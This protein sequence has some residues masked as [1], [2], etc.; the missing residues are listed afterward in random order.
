MF[1]QNEIANL[2]LDYPIGTNDFGTLF[3]QTFE[4]ETYRSIAQFIYMGELDDND[5]VQYDD[6]YNKKERR[7]I[8]DNI[9]ATVQQRFLACQNVYLKAN[10]NATFKTYENVGHWT[11][12]NINLDVI[13]FFLAQMKQ[14][15]K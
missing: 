9:G 10:I 2:K 11:T 15:E 4:F 7:I 6:A 14:H 5:A 8:N 13:K 3:N 1:P 12:S